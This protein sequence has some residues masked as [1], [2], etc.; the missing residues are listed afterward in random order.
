M[1]K[2]MRFRQLVRA[3]LAIGFS[4]AMLAMLPSIIYAL[5]DAYQSDT[6]SAPELHKFRPVGTPE[7]NQ[8]EYCG[9][10]HASWVEEMQA[11]LHTDIA[12]LFCH[13][14]SGGHAASKATSDACIPCHGDLGTSVRVST[15]SNIDCEDS[16]ESPY[17][18]ECTTCHDPHDRQHNLSMIRSKIG[19]PDNLF[20][21]EFFN[22]TGPNSFDEDGG[23]ISDTDDICVTCHINEKSPSYPINRHAGGDHGY[24]GDLR[25]TNCTT[26]HSHD[27]DDIPSTNDGFM[28]SM[29]GVGSHSIHITE[30][31][32]GPVPMGCQDCHNTS[33]FSKFNDGQNFVNTNVCDTCHSPNGGIDGVNH[34]AI[35]AKSNW[36]EGIYDD[37]GETIQSGKEQ[38]CAGCHDNQPA[39]IEET[40]A[41]PVAG[42]NVTYGFYVNGHGRTSANTDCQDCHNVNLSH[43]DGNQR[44]YS[45]D[46]LYYASDQSGSAYSEAYRLTSIDGQVPLMVPANYNLTFGYNAA[47]IR[48]TAFRL[49]F[50]CHDSSQ[51]FDFTP[52]DGINSNFKSSLPNPPQN[53]SYAWGSGSDRSEHTAH[54]LNFI[55]PFW[56]SDWDSLTTSADSIN[57]CDSLLSCSSCHNVH[58]ASGGHGSTN[59]PMIRDGML[60]Q[61]TGYDF[62][63]VI[64]DGDY[65]QVTSIG[66]TQTN[67]V[68]AIFRNDT[69]NMCGGFMCH[70]NPSPPGDSYDASGSGYGT[71]M[72]YYRPWQNYS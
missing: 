71:Y 33:D 8:V 21:I 31:S 57:G 43:I 53:Y 62:T 11:S 30:N 20:D 13:Q 26:C 42:D 46:S 38:W 66:A 56:D 52:E 2:Q 50:D 32:K 16:T 64:P 1:C 39:L 69:G 29:Y 10:C 61:R 65:P 15:H 9:N 54:L 36:N 40:Q 28:V 17:T 58:G 41:P 35:G 25:G 67:S 4:I 5:Q 24:L 6:S 7:E 23:D 51:V 48:D 12:C 60:A 22:I 49:C 27:L 45:F 68:G 37:T 63:Y 44:T 19:P 3:T 59:E 47:L 14:S 34:P 70:S 18:I 72:E 55:G